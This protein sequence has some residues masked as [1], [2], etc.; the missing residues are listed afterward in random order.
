M[1]RNS[2][3]YSYPMIVDIV[4][5]LML[6]VGRHALASRG[7]GAA[8][9]GSI[10]LYYGIGYCVA[11]LFMR[12]IISVRYAR[13][14]MGLALVAA[15]ACC[16]WL[17]CTR[18]VTQILLVFALVPLAFSLFFNAFQAFMLDLS[19]GRA[20]PL[21]ATAGHYTFSWS[22][23]YALGPFVSGACSTYLSWE[24]IYWV[25]AALAGVIGLV[26][27]RLRPLPVGLLP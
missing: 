8:T 3:I 20:K 11:S 10:L 5:G 23:G 17:A 26:A 25:A 27:W 12:R 24:Q 2:V 13:A 1:S 15:A 16:C 21:A 19:D 18:S 6:F 9:V 14:Q 22:L 7:H 4:V